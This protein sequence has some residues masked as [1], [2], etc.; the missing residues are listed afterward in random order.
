MDHEVAD[1]RR[2]RGERQ[3]ALQTREG[4]AERQSDRETCG[5]SE[6]QSRSADLPRR[7]HVEER[8][9]KVRNA[10]LALCMISSTM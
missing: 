9:Q 5:Q 8:D 2:D 7:R 1:E 4:D 3:S 10:G 6:L